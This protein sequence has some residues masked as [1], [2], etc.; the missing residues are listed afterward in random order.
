MLF[1]FIKRGCWTVSPAPERGRDRDT[2]VANPISP[3]IEVGVYLLIYCGYAIYFYSY[4][5]V[6]WGEV[7]VLCSSILL[8]FIY[9]ICTARSD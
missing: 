7:S 1:F 2:I 9:Y 5:G 6:C 8:E 3:D 4:P